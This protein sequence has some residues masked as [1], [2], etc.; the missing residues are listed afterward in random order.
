MDG[1]DESSLVIPLGFGPGG[2]YSCF[3]AIVSH[4]QPFK[5]SMGM[6]FESAKIIGAIHLRSGHLLCSH[7]DTMP[8]LNHQKAHQ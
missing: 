1:M 8:K 5:K 6:V 2:V 3:V 4:G 7:S